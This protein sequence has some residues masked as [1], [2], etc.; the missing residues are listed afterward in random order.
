MNENIET[1]LNKEIAEEL[2]ELDKVELGGDTYKV[3][4]NGISQLV[5]KSIELKK[6]EIDKQQREEQREIDTQIRMQEIE[7][8][9]KDRKTKNRITVVSIVLPLAVG[10]GLSYKTFKFEEEGTITSTV[11]RNIINGLTKLKFWK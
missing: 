7:N 11:G 2:K 8:E 1:L 6:L 9:E 10:V 5:D 4:V 3:T